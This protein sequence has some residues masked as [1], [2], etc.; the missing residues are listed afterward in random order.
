MRRVLPIGPSDHR[1]F[2]CDFFRH[3]SQF[4]S[5]ALS[6]RAVTYN[7]NHGSDA[8]AL[9][10][11]FDVLSSLDCRV[12]LLQ[13]VKRK[14]L[15]RRDPVRA[16][17]DRGLRVKYA[18]PEFA[19]AWNHGDW[20]YVRSWRPLMSPTKY[21]TTNYALVVVLRHRK[22]GLVGKFITYHPPAHVQ[23]PKHK[24]FPV[25]SVVVRQWKTTLNRLARAHFN[26]GAKKAGGIDFVCSGGDDNVDEF[27]G[28]APA[29][30]WEFMLDGPLVQ[31]RPHEPTH[32]NRTIDDFR[33]VGLD[34]AA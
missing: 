13:E 26:R 18:A 19:V 23:A 14:R 31:V 3:V 6:F 5:D 4:A 20:E 25:V 22:T 29:G 24:T 2:V 9:A 28:W 10:H 12:W 8:V 34:A 11:V 21:W 16:L 7:V 15:S 1:P 33:T 30:G 17:R 32:D 27:K